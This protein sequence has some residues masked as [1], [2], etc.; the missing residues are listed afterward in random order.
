MKRERER[1]RACCKWCII[2]FLSISFEVALEPSTLILFHQD[3]EN[4]KD[5]SD[6]EEIPHV[7]IEFEPSGTERRQLISERAEG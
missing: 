2:K 4:R 7:N 6:A 3:Q 1:E 5:D